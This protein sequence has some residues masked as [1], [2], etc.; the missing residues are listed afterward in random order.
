MERHGAD[1][2][3]GVRSNFVWVEPQSSESNVGSPKTKVG[4]QVDAGDG[5]FRTPPA[6]EINKNGHV[7]VRVVVAQVKETPGAC[8]HGSAKE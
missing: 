5:L 1:Q 2:A 4:Q 7:Q 8:H 3:Q 6:I